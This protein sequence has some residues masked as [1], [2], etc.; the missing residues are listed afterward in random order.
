[1]P[2]C[3]A[4]SHLAFEDLGL[5]QPI[6]QRRG[7]DIL[8]VDVPSQGV[9]DDLGDL[10]VVLGGPIGVYDHPLYPFLTAEI[11]AL[12][13]RLETR[14]PTLGLCL[15]AQVL[16]VAAGGSVA[17]NPLGKE[18]GW[19]PV[20]ITPA[21]LTSP[22]CHLDGTAVLHWHGDI[23]TPPPQARILAATAKTACQAFAIG[24]T[25]LGLQFHPEV[26]ALGLE[27]WLVGNVLELSLGHID[28]TQMRA[29]NH[30]LAPLLIPAVEAL[31]H[32]WLDEAGL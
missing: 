31:A 2:K 24:P 6:L 4:L 14:S 30:A 10:C 26:T 21:G 29:D 1:M 18:I 13:T 25:A 7:F 8:S 9:P 11:A 28:I 12:Q 5:L 16:A 17:P 19:S 23:I 32:S 3:V 15:G 20:Q 27:R 22:L